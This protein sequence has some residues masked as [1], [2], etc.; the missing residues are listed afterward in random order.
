MQRRWPSPL[1]EGSSAYQI[2]SARDKIQSSKFQ[3]YYEVFIN[4]LFHN[5][6]VCTEVS[7]SIRVHHL[8]PDNAVEKSRDAIPPDAPPP[9]PCEE[10]RLLKAA[11]IGAPNVGKSTLVN[12]LLGA[13]LFA[14]SPKVHTTVRKAIGVFTDGNA[15]GVCVHLVWGGGAFVRWHVDPL[16][17]IIMVTCLVIV[18]RLLYINHAT[19]E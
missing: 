10:Q 6:S 16:P 19:Y 4:I 8:E 17:I 11:V 1:L 3:V 7:T 13:K 2:R 12:Q 18:S 14:V 15:H 9:P 5:P